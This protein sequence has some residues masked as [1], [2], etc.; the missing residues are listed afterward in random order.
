MIHGSVPKLRHVQPQNPSGRVVP[1]PRPVP[2]ASFVRQA[3]RT[4][5]RKP[6]CFEVL[7]DRS[8]AIMRAIRIFLR[9]SRKPAP[10]GIVAETSLDQ[11]R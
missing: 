2:S 9:E 8:I 6:I 1:L 3:Q 10:R 7:R 5:Q 11:L 4:T